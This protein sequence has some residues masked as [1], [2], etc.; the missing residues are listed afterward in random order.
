MSTAHVRLEERVAALEREI[1]KVKSTLQTLHQKSRQPWWEQLA[2]TFKNDPVF[3][4]IVKAGQAYRR[5]L[6]DRGR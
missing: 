1:R 5:S 3:N 6:T 4:E 2:G